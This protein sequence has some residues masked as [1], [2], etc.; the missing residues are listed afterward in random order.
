MRM[1][2]LL[3]CSPI[4][5]FFGM[6]VCLANLIL[7][8]LTHGRAKVRFLEYLYFWMWKPYSINIQKSLVDLT[9]MLPKAKTVKKRHQVNICFICLAI[10]LSVKSFICFLVLDQCE[11]QVSHL[12]GFLMQ[13]IH[14]TFF[15]VCT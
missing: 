8:Y 9:G 7:E 15:H 10:L 11:D 14:F 12:W 13:K 2:S 4:Y 1:V 6:L 3:F 5:W